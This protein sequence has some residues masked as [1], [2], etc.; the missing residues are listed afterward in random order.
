MPSHRATNSYTRVNGE[1]AAACAEI[2]HAHPGGATL[3]RDAAHTN[4]E[5]V[6]KRPGRHL[7]Q[8]ARLGTDIRLAAVLHDGFPNDAGLAQDEALRHR[9]RPETVGVLLDPDEGSLEAMRAVFES[10]RLIGTAADKLPTKLGSL[11]HSLRC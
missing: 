11:L 1:E 2:R 5:D 9:G 10:D 8:L 4:W 3:T 6:G 7:P